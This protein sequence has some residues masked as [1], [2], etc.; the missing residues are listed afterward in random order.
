MLDRGLAQASVVLTL[1]RETARLQGQSGELTASAGGAEERI[2]EME[3][4]LLSLEA[5]RRE[6][7]ITRLRDLQFNE[8]ELRENRTTLVRQLARLSIRAPVGGIGYGL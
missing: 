2:T 7:A 8:L 6:E 1:Q 3:I 4:E 5:A